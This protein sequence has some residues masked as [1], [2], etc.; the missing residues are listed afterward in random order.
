MENSKIVVGDLSSEVFKSGEHMIGI[1][2]GSMPIPRELINDEVPEEEKKNA[3]AT[4]IAL[5]PHQAALIYEHGVH[6]AV[7][8][9]TNVEQ[10]GVSGTG[11]SGCGQNQFRQAL[12]VCNGQGKLWDE[13]RDAIN[14]L[15]AL[16]QVARKTG[17]IDSAKNID[18]TLE[19]LMV[20]VVTKNIKGNDLSQADSDF[21]DDDGNAPPEFDNDG[22][23]PPSLN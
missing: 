13:L 10:L 19:E 7:P 4:V 21:A 9:V 8:V 17:V 23:E 16:V 20:A 22:P 15:V 12:M 14:D 2:K 1:L 18:M 11:C 5:A 6:L 3:R